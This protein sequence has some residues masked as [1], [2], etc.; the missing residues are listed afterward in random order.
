[1]CWERWVEAEQEAGRRAEP[2][3]AEAPEAREP[4]EMV[5]ALLKQPE[6]VEHPSGVPS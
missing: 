6:T 1:M 3:R 2:V 4:E 5:Q